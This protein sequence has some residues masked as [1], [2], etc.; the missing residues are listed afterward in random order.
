MRFIL[1]MFGWLFAAG[2]IAFVIGAV[3]AGGFLWHYSKDLPDSA[4]LRL[5][6]LYAGANYR[7]TT[8]VV[9]VPIPRAGSGVGAPRI[10]DLE[11]IAFVAGLL[12]AI[13][14]DGQ[15][16]VDITKFGGGA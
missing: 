15:A 6:R 9:Q 13:A 1:R 5:K 3:V 8:S 12:V 14:G 11:L 16:P 2:A 7:A 4:Q 10:R